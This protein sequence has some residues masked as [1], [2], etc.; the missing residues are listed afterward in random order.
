MPAGAP[1]KSIFAIVRRYARPVVQS[2]GICL[3]GACLGLQTILV[4]WRK[5]P[6]NR[7]FAIGARA[8]IPEAA[9]RPYSRRSRVCHGWLI[10]ACFARLGISHVGGRRIGK[11][12]DRHPMPSI[13]L[14][15]C[16]G[17]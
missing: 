2:A 16:S 1:A 17:K 12:A 15:C 7:R 4:R 14:Y 6:G 3:V 13:C 9:R 5:V 11:P 10:G 8:A